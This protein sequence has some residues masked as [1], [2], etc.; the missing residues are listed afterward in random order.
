MH[1]G[2]LE[3]DTATFPGQASWCL[4]HPWVPCAPLCIPDKEKGPSLSKD[5]VLMTT[6]DKMKIP[7]WEA[8][9]YL[10][11]QSGFLEAAGHSLP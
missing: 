1:M 2:D 7:F 8:D 10:Q 5:V 9:L 3:N 6:R 4:V 11:P